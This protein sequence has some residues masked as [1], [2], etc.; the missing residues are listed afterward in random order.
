MLCS[1]SLQLSSEEQAY[2]LILQIY[3]LELQ[4]YPVKISDLSSKYCCSAFQS[5]DQS[6]ALLYPLNFFRV[7]HCN[8]FDGQTGK[9]GASSWE[10]LGHGKSRL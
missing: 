7:N 4:I 5:Y 1:I 9:E 3:V 6:F 8:D 2:L 10:F